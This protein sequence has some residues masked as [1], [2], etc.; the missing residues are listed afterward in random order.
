MAQIAA[1][2]AEAIEAWIGVRF[3][4]FVQFRDIVM[5]GLALRDALAELE[6][7]DGVRASASTWIV[8]ARAPTE[9]AP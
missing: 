9:L 4:R 5:T 3:D 1:A 7:A 6:G 2:N 8:S